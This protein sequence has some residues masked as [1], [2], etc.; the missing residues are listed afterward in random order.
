MELGVDLLNPLQATA[1]DLAAVRTKTQGRTALMGGVSSAMLMKA[2]IREVQEET[3]RT[4]EQY[5]YYPIAR[6]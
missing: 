1:N 4:V 5:G 6:K 3:I 2:S